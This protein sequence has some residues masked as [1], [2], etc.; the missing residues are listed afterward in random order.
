[1]TINPC[2]VCVGTT[3]LKPVSKVRNLGSWFD[4][5]FSMSIH[6]SKSC[7]GALFFWLHNVKQISKF[8]ARDKLEIVLQTIAMDFFMVFQIVK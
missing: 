8:L 1:M 3:D 2:S 7:S 4:S 6:I 5:I